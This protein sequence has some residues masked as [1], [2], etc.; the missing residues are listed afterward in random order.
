VLYDLEVSN[1]GGAFDLEHGEF[2][3]PVGG[4]YYVSLQAC[5]SHAMW[6]T[7]AIMKDGAVIGK[8]LSGDADY[9]SS[10]SL[11]T[12][13]ASGDKMWVVKVEGTT[14]VLSKALAW[15]TFTAVPIG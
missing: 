4:T 2:T 12:E 5:V 6:M 11:V 3:A 1:I 8:L 14:A 9:C 10:H 13:L 15:N 7:L